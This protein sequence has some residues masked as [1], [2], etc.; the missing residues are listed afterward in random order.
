MLRPA[1]PLTLLASLIVPGV[2]LAQD[3]P[4]PAVVFDLYTTHIARGDYD[5]ALSWCRVPGARDPQATRQLRDA[6]GDIAS[7]VDVMGVVKALSLFVPLSPTPLEWRLVAAPPPVG[8]EARL[9]FVAST[10]LTFDHSIYFVRTGPQWQIDLQRTLLENARG[11]RVERILLERSSKDAASQQLARVARATLRY[12]E[13]HDGRLP[14]AETWQQDL[15]AYTDVLSPEDLVSPLTPGGP[16]TY[17]LNENLAG[18]LGREITAPDKTV[19]VFDAAPGIL[20]GGQAA[21]NFRHQGEAMALLADGTVVAMGSVGD[22]SWGARPLAPSAGSVVVPVTVVGGVEMVPIRDVIQ[23]LGGT[24]TWRDDIR[25]S[26]AEALGHKV[27]IKSGERTVRIDDADVPLAAAPA[28][29]GDRLMVPVGLASRGFGLTVRWVQ[30][31][32]EFK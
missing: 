15:L 10:T 25:A 6:M 26:L 17:A 20:S 21:A 4:D 32:V 11:T 2:C 8:D 7:E 9:D 5:G 12:L 18:R 31:G 19:L 13:E 23:P 28:T 29:V 1:V 14:A 27:T 24:V 22:Y 30:G 16:T 3:A